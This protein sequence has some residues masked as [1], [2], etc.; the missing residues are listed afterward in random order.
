MLEMPAGLLR[1]K[2]KTKQNNA[3]EVPSALMQRKVIRSFWILPGGDQLR[4]LASEKYAEKPQQR[5]Y[6]K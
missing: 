4:P 3:P 5:L 6:I 2:N 1:T